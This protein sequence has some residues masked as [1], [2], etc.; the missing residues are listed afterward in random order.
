MTKAVFCILVS[1]A[2]CICAFSCVLAEEN[3]SLFP[4]KEGWYYG[5][6]HQD[7]SWA[8]MPDSFTRAYPFQES[9]LAPVRVEIADLYSN[10]EPFRMVNRQGETAV[11]LEEWTLGME[12]IG[13][14]YNLQTPVL[15]GNANILRL[16]ADNQRY[17]LYL[18]HTGK[19]IELTPEFLGY[20]PS[21]ESASLG[22]IDDDSIF[23]SEPGG[24]M[25]YQW[26]D[27]LLLRFWVDENRLEGGKIKSDLVPMFVILD[28]DG[29]K[30]HEGIFRE[31][32]EYFPDYDPRPIQ[33]SYLPVLQ[34]DGVAFVNMDGKIVLSGLPASAVLTPAG[35]AADLSDGSC[36]RLMET[37]EE[38]TPLEYA[39]H[40]AAKNPSGLAV[41]E[42]GYIN[43]DGEKM[44]WPAI[45]YTDL[46][47]YEFTDAGVAWVYRHSK[48]GYYLIDSKGDILV[49][50][51]REYFWHYMGLEW[52]AQPA[53]CFIQGWEPVSMD[54]GKKNYMNCNGEL[55][56]PGA[57]FEETDPFQGGLARA[58]FWTEGCRPTE[59]YINESGKV[60]WAE[61]GQ[62]EKIQQWLD[63]DVSF[64]MQKLTLE[65][66]AQLLIGDW[67]LIVTAN[68]GYA[69]SFREDGRCR[70]GGY[71]WKL[72]ENHDSDMECDF[73]LTIY[74]EGTEKIV[75]QKGIRFDSTD[76]FLLYSVDGYGCEGYQRVAPGYCRKK[77]TDYYEP[78]TVPERKVPYEDDFFG[79]VE[80]SVQLDSGILNYRRSGH[81]NN[82]F[83]NGNSSKLP[84]VSG[85]TLVWEQSIGPAAIYEDPLWQPLVIK[86]PVQ[87]REVSTISDPLKEKT[88]LKEVIAVGTDHN[89]H[90]FELITGER[91]RHP[92]DGSEERYLGTPALHE[93]LPVMAVPAENGT[94]FLQ[95]T[96]G[97]VITRDYD[98]L[99]TPRL[100]L[101]QNDYLL[102][103]TNDSI[104]F[105][106]AEATFSLSSG[107]AYYSFGV[108][109]GNEYSFSIQPTG[110]I[111][112]DD[113]TLW[114]SDPPHTVAA[115]S[116]TE[117]EILEE[118]WH[119]GAV[120][121]SI[122][123]KEE[124]SKKRLF[125]GTTTLDND[126]SFITLECVDGNTLESIWC[127][128]IPVVT[129]EP[130]PNGCMASPVIGENALEGI[131][132]FTL[133]G[134]VQS[135][136]DKN[137]PGSVPFTVALNA[138]TGALLWSKPM[139]G[140]TVSSPV[141][142]YSNESKGYILQAD[143]EG[144]LYMF[145]GITGTVV[146]TLDLGGKVTSAPAVFHN[147][148]VIRCTKGDEEILCSIQL[149]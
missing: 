99:R 121:S 53:D 129:D 119:S 103:Q 63:N 42:S 136:H 77:G 85:L 138:D 75:L 104:H 94:V 48:H 132:Y 149:N 78:Y 32:A 22:R 123:I 11:F 71:L 82:G 43:A 30:I 143:G 72:E 13:A 126:L 40:C 135:P 140:R 37:G 79:S 107:A 89:I 68:D 87:I 57:P 144:T 46:I 96:D 105:T 6:I 113:S 90:L 84:E 122:A 142:V 51:P 17:A 74:E 124:D 24:F 33:E 65:E 31:N 111:S 8:I 97:S 10:D 133:T 49:S 26:Q 127:N 14:F 101:W 137:E 148:M 27:R 131:V 20:T 147:F 109:L 1:L 29:N 76:Y 21:F 141:A 23:E 117:G 116:M 34:E 115:Y 83:S 91:T 16:R 67:E 120:L 62:A 3:Q 54:F 88:A 70:D 95:M 86:W 69:E 112:A 39:K 73:L 145:D 28:K 128:R 4:A 118:L 38:L 12:Y 15:A 50:E 93:Q 108:D 44:D 25:I 81:R 59:I 98:F 66:T 64:S 47:P 106:M 110:P 7:G 146:D 125:F 114:Y 139:N 58:V 5:Y 100:L 52:E 56:F 61:G 9:G 19:L 18:S 55:L 41:Y 2:L 134:T 60:V 92:I 45:A 130:L 80:E 102:T 36:F 35:D